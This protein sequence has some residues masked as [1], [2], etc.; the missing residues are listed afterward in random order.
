MLAVGELLLLS[1][2]RRRRVAPQPRGSPVSSSR[3][4]GCSANALVIADVVHHGR[5]VDDRSAV[6]IGDV[7]NV[8]VIHCPVVVEEPVAPIPARIANSEVAEAVVNATIEPDHW[9]PEACIPHKPAVV[10]APV[11]RGPKRAH[12]GRQHPCPGHPVVTVNRVPSPITW[13]PDVARTRANR[14]DVHG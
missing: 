9:P 7:L 5:V 6:H 1:L 13:G 14:L 8:E 3:L 2:R 12:E 4:G 10:P 11:A